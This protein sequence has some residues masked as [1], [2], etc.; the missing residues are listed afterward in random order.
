MLYNTIEVCVAK[1]IILCGPP[2]SGKSTYS[3]LIRQPFPFIR[4][5]QDEQGR[6][7]LKL[8]HEA[9]NSG[10]NIV[11][12]RMNF[13]KKQRARYLL[14]AKE[15]GYETEIVVFHVP[16]E[17]C[18]ERC[19]A[20]KDHPTIKTEQDVG[21]ATG[22]F[23]KSYERVTDD[24]AD[25]VT[26][27]G[28]EEAKGKCVTFDI[29]GTL[30]NIDH[31]LQYVDKSLGKKHWKKF[32]DE[33][34]NDSVYEYCVDIFKGFYDARVYSVVCASGRSDEYRKDTTTWLLNNDLHAERLFMRPRDDYRDDTIVKE[35][36]LEFELKTRYKE[37]L[38]VDDRPK[39]CRMWR[40]HGYRCL[41]VQDKEF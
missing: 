32:S 38:F 18:Q 9:I 6:D 25:K 21:K 29:D 26:R 41:Q 3:S 13:D 30:A 2:G 5:S 4:I 12:D 36:I 17:I 37:L 40:S 27:L 20:R 39:V 34:V 16:K 19:R 1:I 15:A 8:F 33:C 24:E 22:F 31:R 14:S 11:V 23:F 10:Q 7:H 28:W 35:I